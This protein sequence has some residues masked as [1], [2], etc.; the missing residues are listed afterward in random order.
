VNGIIDARQRVHILPSY[1][2][3]A[4]VIDTES[5]R[6]IMLLDENNRRCPRRASR[7]GDPLLKHFVWVCVSIV[8]FSAAEAL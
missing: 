6:A 2:I 5:G 1:G 4:A 7:L 3:E 8:S